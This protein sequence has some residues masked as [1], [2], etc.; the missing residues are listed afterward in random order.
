MYLEVFRAF[1]FLSDKSKQVNG[2][3]GSYIGIY[4]NGIR[5]AAE[6]NMGACV[7]QLRGAQLKFCH[8]KVDEI[9]LSF[10]MSLS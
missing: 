6:K 4:M 7:A 1:K 9:T 10:L 2:K 8:L 5:P 3:T